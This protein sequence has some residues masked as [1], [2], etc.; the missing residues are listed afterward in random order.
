MRMTFA[1]RIM[2]IKALPYEKYAS[3]S[4]REKLVAYAM[5][6]LDE[7]GIPLNFNNICVTAFRLFPEKF[8]F[9]E[10]FKEYPHIEML[11]R[12]ILHLRPVERNYATG[13]VKTDYALTPIGR[14][15]AEQVKTDIEAGSHKIEPRQIMDSHK[16][17]SGNDLRNL[18][19][20]PLFGRWVEGSSLDDMEIWDFFGVTPFTQ[21]D[22]VKKSISDVSEY[23]KS[24]N[25][26]EAV[27]FL[28]NLRKR[29][30]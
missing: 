27:K 6:Y 22:K 17:T 11:N 26:D 20:S 23:A 16:K 12:T 28:D 15:I 7:L 8:Y 13:S 29:I 21:I 24:I 18:R 1:E 2:T 9:S 5:S 25:D 10:D 3:V 30:E 4:S 14:E 19:N